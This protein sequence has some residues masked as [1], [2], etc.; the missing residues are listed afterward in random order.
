[1]AAGLEVREGA[2]DD[3]KEAFNTAASGV[4]G[5]V[6]LSLTQRVDAVL[7]EEMP[8]WHFYESLL[9]LRPFG[10]DNPE[11]VWAMQGVRLA[12]SPRVVGQ[13]HLKLSFAAGNQ[14]FDAIAFNCPMDSLPD[15]LMDIAFTLKENL[16]NGR[17]SLQMQIKDIRPAAPL[18]REERY[19]D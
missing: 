14:V 12:A 8:S 5:N 9:R 17:R 6:D 7:D 19:A 11:P 18:Q 10:Q 4:L 2:L 1:M 13:Q 15:G 3:F 16:W